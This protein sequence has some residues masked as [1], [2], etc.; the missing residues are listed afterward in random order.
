MFTLKYVGSHVCM[1]GLVHESGS[2]SPSGQSLSPSHFHVS[3]IHRPERHRKWLSGQARWVQLA[4]S[5]ELKQNDIFII[6]KPKIFFIIIKIA[7]PSGQSWSASQTQTAGIHLLS[8]PHRCWLDGQVTGGQSFSSSPSGQSAWSSHRWF[9][10]MQRSDN[11]PLP[12]HLNWELRQ[13]C[14]SHLISS[15]PSP[16]SD[17]P[18][19]SNDGWM[20]CPLLHWNWP[21]IQVKAGQSA[22]SSDRSPQSS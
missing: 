11:V 3:G 2:S 18:L 14:V 8:V 10:S 7:Y 21:G 12:R 6:N 13:V 9:E 4:G 22:G 5:S 15:E 20:Q 19:Q 17:S 16:Q 1:S